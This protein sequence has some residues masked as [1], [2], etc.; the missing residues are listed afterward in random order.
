MKAFKEALVTV[1]SEITP[2]DNNGLPLV[3]EDCEKSSTTAPAFLKI[4]DGCFELSYCE[5]QNG[6]R[7][8]TDIVICDNYV[9]VRHSGAIE[10]NF[11]FED[12]K[13]HSSLYKIP[14]YEFETE[15]ITNKIRNGITENGG[16]LTIFYDMT[17]GNDRRGVKMR[18]E[19]CIQ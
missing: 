11:V 8:N 9:S 17:I 5:E 16:T 2:L 7:V 12:G 3:G 6:E 1:T 14:P 10:S 4:E 15:I 19:V 13:S 18:I